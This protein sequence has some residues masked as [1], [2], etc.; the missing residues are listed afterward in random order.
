MRDEDTVTA[1][2]NAAVDLALITEPMATVMEDLE[3]AVKWKSIGDLLPGLQPGCILFGP[4]LLTTRP[5]VG[6]RW[7]RAYLRGVRDYDAAMGRP[8]GRQEV[9]A[10]LARHTPVRDLRLYDRMGFVSLDPAGRVDEALLSE[11]LAW[12][13]EQGL[14]TAPVDLPRILEP[15]F[16]RDS[17]AQLGAYS[18]L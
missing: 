15:S 18:K 4:D 8:S 14:V 16:A 6:R 13:R 9:A 12:Y 2:R 17:A 1:L 3:I 11:Q 10:I 5:E 7:M